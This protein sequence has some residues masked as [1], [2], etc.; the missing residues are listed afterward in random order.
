MLIV[1]DTTV[2][3]ACVTD[4]PHREALL[5]ATMN[6]QL[7]APQSLLWEVGNALSAMFKRRRI[8]LEAAIQA[9]ELYKRMP[10]HSI[11]CNSNRPYNWPS[12]SPFTHMMRI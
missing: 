8:S 11:P 2:V 7:L 1:V 6:H 12:N 3:I 5:A 9:V 10:V 4:E